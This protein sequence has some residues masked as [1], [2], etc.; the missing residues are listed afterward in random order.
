ME[1]D[2][3]NSEFQITGSLYKTN[4]ALLLLIF[5]MPFRNIQIQYLPNFGFGLNTVNILFLLSVYHAFRHGI[6]PLRPI[7][8]NNYILL[9]ILSGIIAY[10]V[11]FG[12]LG[13]DAISNWKDLK[14]QSIPLFLEFVI[15]RSAVD[16]VQWNR[17]LLSAMLSIPYTFRLV[18]NQYLAVSRYHYSDSLRIRG[19]FMDLGA[20]ELGA[21][22][23]TA[24]LVLVALLITCWH[25]K[26][27]RYILILL[28][29]GAL[30]ALLYSYSR[31][32]YLAFIVG[33]L[34]VIFNF[35]KS[36]KLLIPILLISAVGINFLPKSVEERFTSIEASE[37][38]R[39]ESAK[40]RFVFWQIAYENFKEQPILGYGFK[41]AADVRINPYQ[42]DT[43]NYFIKILEERG[44]VGSVILILLLLSIRKMIKSKLDWEGNNSI[45]NGVVL[46][47]FGAYYAL[48]VGNMF[49]DRFSHMSIVTIFW[50]VIGL[51][52][53]IEN[54]KNNEKKEKE[55]KHAVFKEDS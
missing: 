14:D 3:A 27:I 20:N 36:V 51:T 8:M 22:A 33:F 19:P 4:W 43:H 25:I 24:S 13:N 35:K 9:F 21:Y 37:E 52:S 7:S 15:Q 17:I 1:V 32:G 47:A 23:V 12:L 45:I 34:V 41:T 18:Y 40:S 11:S 38:N 28:S 50:T 26:K 2:N 49:G 39:D 30:G 10:F 31:G 53:V 42:M 48:L 55:N 6:K 44:V 54:H 5:I 46:G 16:R 29:I